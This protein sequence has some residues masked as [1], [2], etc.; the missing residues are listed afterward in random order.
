MYLWYKADYYADPIP[1]FRFWSGPQNMYHSCEIE[2]GFL[3]GDGARVGRSFFC[4]C[5][6]A[7]RFL[8]S[9]N[10]SQRRPLLRPA[11]RRVHFARP[12]TQASKHSSLAAKR[13]AEASRGIFFQNWVRAQHVSCCSVCTLAWY[14]TTKDARWVRCSPCSLGPSP[15]RPT[16]RCSLAAVRRGDC[17]RASWLYLVQRIER[18]SYICVLPP[19]AAVPGRLCSVW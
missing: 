5:D 17:V 1:S 13:R 10:S 16:A 15:R 19:T 14:L 12:W 7:V 2:T 4:S 9:E 11:P 8:D 18:Y 6:S 3:C